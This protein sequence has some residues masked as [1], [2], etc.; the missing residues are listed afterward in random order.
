MEKSSKFYLWLKNYIKLKYVSLIFSFLS[1]IALLFSAFL[2]YQSLQKNIE[3]S[4]TMQALGIE[5]VLKSLLQYFDLSVL[6]RNRE[7]FLDLLLNEKWEGVA[8]IALYDRDK[9]ILLHSNPELIGQKVEISPLLEE[10]KSTAYL[11]LKTGEKVFLYEDYLD[12]KDIKAVLRIALHITPVEE[13]LAYVKGHLYLELGLAFIFFTGGVIAFFL[14]NK[15]EK[16]KEKTEELE[17]WQFISKIL[18]HEIKNPLASIKGFAQYLSKKCSDLTFSKPLEIIQ[19][20][21]LRIEKLLKELYE[22]SFTPEVELKSLNLK[23]QLEEIIAA[24]KFI[25]PQIEINFF[26]DENNYFLLSDAEKLKSIITNLLD[27]AI[28]ATLA[29]DQKMVEVLL[30]KEKEYYFIKIADRGTGI[31]EELLPHIFKPF[32]TTKAKGTGLGL[33]IVKKFCEELKIELKFES[34]E[35]K[36]TTVWLKI[37]VSSS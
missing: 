30:K 15:W 6:Q 29:N 37:P 32:F 28:A 23:E 3:T 22:Y 35:G 36:G 11:T 18:L 33:A 9:K 1:G 12:I 16:V 27:N 13:V 17:K 10:K 24:L 14:F 31:A 20:E 2:S 21:A 5:V 25:Y 8:Y 26:C 34:I 4:L 7:F 19:R